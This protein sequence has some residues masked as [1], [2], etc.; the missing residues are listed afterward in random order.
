MT[1]ATTD[2]DSLSPRA[3]RA[4]AGEIL[5]VVRWSRQQLLELQRERLQSVIE[6]AVMRSPYYREALGLDATEADLPDL[7]TYPRPCSWS[8]STES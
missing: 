8:S 2:T 6:H 3:L 7:P 5:A 4:R 1:A